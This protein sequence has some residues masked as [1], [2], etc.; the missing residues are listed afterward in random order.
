MT[1]VTM[2]DVILCEFGGSIEIINQ[3]WQE[4]PGEARCVSDVFEDWTVGQQA[5]CA[6]PCEYGQSGNCT[7]KIIIGSSGLEDGSQ[8]VYE[9]RWRSVYIAPMLKNVFRDKLPSE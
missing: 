8:V 5:I 9:S 2:N 1:S 7:R 6:S 3:E 4:E